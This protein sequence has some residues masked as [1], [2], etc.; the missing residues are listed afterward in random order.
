VSSLDELIASWA[1]AELEGDSDTLGTLLHSRFLAVG[2][3]GFLL[4]REQWKQ[5][6]AG[7]L[8]GERPQRLATPATTPA[9]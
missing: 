2:P 3:Y 8:V 5:R 7:G 4:D 6:F 9:D 1:R